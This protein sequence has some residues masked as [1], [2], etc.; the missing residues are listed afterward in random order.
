MQ[1]PISTF[2]GIAAGLVLASNC[3][4]GCPIHVPADYPTIQ[5][6]I[7]AAFG[8]EII[9]APGTYNEIISNFGI[10]RSS[11]GPDVTIIDASGFNFSVVTCTTGCGVLEGFTITGGSAPGSL[12]GGW[13][14]QNASP[15]TTVINC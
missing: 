5:A 6:A 8:G 9:V 15:A 4:A 13:Y 2:L 1:Q 12:G 7:D 14:N 3:G 10:V 11:D